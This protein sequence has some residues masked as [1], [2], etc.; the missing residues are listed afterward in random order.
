MKA[1]LISDNHDSLIGMRLA[2][3]E[4]KIVR[5]QDE[6]YSVLETQMARHDLAILLM[7][8]KTAEMIPDAVK[9]L[10]ENNELPLL[11]EIPDRFG[12]KRGDNFLTQYVQEAIG[13]KM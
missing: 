2:G 12:T 5:N 9:H 11:I 6:A 13:V 7:T 1:F 10:R 4:G 3:I 8:E